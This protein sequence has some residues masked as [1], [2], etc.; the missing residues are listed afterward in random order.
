MFTQ[1]SWSSYIVTILLLSTA[2]YLLLAF[3]YY[4]SDIVKIFAGKKIIGVENFSIEFQKPMLQSFSVQVRAFL[5]EAMKNNLNKED[6]MGSI[7]MLIRKYPGVKDMI[8]RNS[9]E[10]LII[11]ESAASIHLSEQ[12]LGELW[13]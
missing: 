6:I 4:K 13:N 5:L 1:I 10:H 9:I 12:D 3:R 7:Q 11:E 2:Y 8:F